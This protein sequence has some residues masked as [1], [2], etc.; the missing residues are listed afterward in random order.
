VSG[1]RDNERHSHSLAPEDEE[2]IR[3]MMK[4]A[5]RKRMRGLRRTAPL[6]ACAARSAKIVAA[7]EAHEAVQRASTVASF[8]PMLERH[9]VDLRELDR[10]LRARGVTMAYPRVE[11][12]TGAMTFHVVDDVA[13]LAEAGNGFAEPP[14]AA[15]ACEALDLIL[16]PALA[17]DPSGQRIGYGAGYYDRAL[18]TT[19]RKTTIAVAYDW[20]L[21]AEIPKTEHDV[22]V[23]WVITD[24]RR[25][26]SPPG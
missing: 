4:A 5:L 18:K 11:P 16:V 24:Q 1:S 6:E 20:Q 21:V 26:R 15:P 7:L 12:E 8:W 9:E 23:D 25:F 3:F 13:S 2:A 19:P 22:A 14:G 17:V 10:V